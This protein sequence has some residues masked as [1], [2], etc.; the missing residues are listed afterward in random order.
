MDALIGR[1]LDALKAQGLENDT[2]VIYTS[3]H[4]DMQT[5]HGMTCKSIQAFYEEILRVPLIA[6]YPKTIKPGKLIDTHANSVDM[7]PTLLDFVGQPIPKG[8]Q[9]VSLKPLLEGKASDDDRPA[10]CERTQ[11]PTNVS[12]MIRTPDWKYSVYAANRRELLDLKNDPCE[13][14]NLAD[15][16]KRK[17]IVEEMHKR[18]RQQMER[19][20]DPALDALPKA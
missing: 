19:T 12:R 10:F 18:L 16:E 4:G 7:M 15:D 1:I 8:V 3:D 2:L 13:I 6:R 14:K 20:S 5:A 17:P 9:G 11:S